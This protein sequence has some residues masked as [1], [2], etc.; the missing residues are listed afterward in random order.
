MSQKEAL[1]IRQKILG[2]LVRDAR[3]AAGKSMKELGEVIGV[4][5]GSIGSIERG[6]RSPSLPEL[7]L[8]AFYLETP[9]DHFWSEEIVSE[10]PHPSEKLEAESLLQKRDRTIGSLIRQGRNE[11]NLS[12][13]DLGKRT[14]ISASRIRR[15]EAGESP[16]PIPELEA[17]AEA[18]GYK[19]DAFLDS[20]GLVGDWIRQQRQIENFLK[21]P[22]NLREFVSNPDNRSYL[23][24]AQRLNNMSPEKL[25]SIANSLSDLSF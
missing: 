7:E 8:M 2:V 5:G 11:K 23:E 22:K 4:S 13:K 3:N 1:K 20:S 21:L 15:Y 6:S 24:I 19:L 9:I 18:L 25:G 12:Q 17:L 16:V 14:D 10:E